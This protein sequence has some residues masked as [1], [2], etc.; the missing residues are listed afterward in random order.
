MLACILGRDVPTT[1]QCSSQLNGFSLVAAGSLDS[2]TIAPVPDG[3]VKGWLLSDLSE[4]ETDRL[5]Y[6]QEALGFKPKNVL[7]L[8]ESKQS[9]QAMTYA[10]DSVQHSDPVAWTFADWVET[11]AAQSMRFSAEIMGQFGRLSAGEMSTRLGPMRMRAAAWVAAQQRPAHRDFDTDTDV[12]VHRRSQPYLNFY[13]IEEMDLQFRRY[14]GTFSEVLKRGS[15]VSG[16]AVVVLPYDPK[17]DEV[18]LIEQFRAPVFIGGS[19]APWVWEAIAGLVDPGEAPDVAARREAQEEA[20][21]TLWHLDP[22]GETYSSTGSQTE[23]L[24][25]YIGLSDFSD[26]NGGGGLATEGED[27]RSQVLSFDELMEGVDQR[28]YVELQ[29]VTLALWLARHRDRLRAM[30]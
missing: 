13:A 6:Y 28:I 8:S 12:I 19:R 29:L 23:Y 20:G 2:V 1:A 7:V 10:P 9:K 30:T 11:N 5:R 4:H 25:L 14:D 21:V 3:V 15:L 18:L 26:L 22:A 17:R 24:Y 16:E 27:I